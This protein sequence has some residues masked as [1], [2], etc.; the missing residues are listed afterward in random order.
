MTDATDR[1]MGARYRLDEADGSW[2]EV[3]WD[4]PLATFYAQHYSPVP[5]D[6]FSGADLVDWHGTDFAELPTTKAL[7]DRLPMALPEE[8][9]AELAADAGAWPNL[10]LPP[11]LATA[12][13]LVDALAGAPEPH[14]G[15]TLERLLGSDVSGVGQGDG[16]PA[17]GDDERRWSLPTGPVANVLR[18]F[19]ADPAL[20]DDDLSTFATGFGLPAR[21]VES[22]LR[23]GVDELGITDVAAVCEGLCC[24]PAQLW[25]AELAAEIAHAYGPADWPSHTEPLP[26]ADGANG[27]LNDGAPSTNGAGLAV[28]A[29]WYAEAGVV[30]V[31]SV[32]EVVPIDDIGRTADAELDYHCRYRQLADPLW[33]AVPLDDHSF[34]SGPTG[35][36]D[37]EPALVE[38][39]QR[40]REGAWPEVVDMVRLTSP[41]AGVEEW[42]GWDP[43][44]RRWQTWDDPRR[45][46]EGAPTDVL[47]PS[48][49]ADP[50]PGADAQLRLDQMLIEPTDSSA[51][52][53]SIELPSSAAIDL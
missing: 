18:A 32:G 11:F 24:T 17:N 6:P 22:V 43:R 33:V 15:A 27:S 38:V 7:A 36:I 10:G 48:G 1:P 16:A 49:F 8:V 47:D 19:H 52:L 23:G 26:G 20:M 14:A 9:D 28:L 34:A 37:A 13:H 41:G 53:D 31:D 4:R 40:L 25:G 42:V 39:A 45:Y 29:T 21:V 12:R 46:F 2:W 35:G 44:T 30:A 3:G 51:G 50:T 5:V